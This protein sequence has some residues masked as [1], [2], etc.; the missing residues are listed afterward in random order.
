MQ[1]LMWQMGG[2]GPMIGQVHHFLRNAK[3]KAPYAE[4]RYLK[5]AHRLYGVLDKRL[6]EAEYMAGA[7]SIADMATWPWIS[8]FEWHQVDIAKYPNVLRWYKAIAARPA[9]VK[10]YHIPVKQ[11]GIP[12]PA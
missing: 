5:E 7:Y 8:R 4:E 9:V 3:G 6:S 2:V 1:W 11:P 10:G 12:M